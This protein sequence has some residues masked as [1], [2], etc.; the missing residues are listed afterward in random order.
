MITGMKC[1]NRGM[2]CKDAIAQIL[3]LFCGFLEPGCINA[4]SL[5][6]RRTLV[7]LN[8]DGAI[9]QRGRKALRH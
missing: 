4:T 2:I 1:H 7:L 6:L 5:Y 3:H 8:V 9:R